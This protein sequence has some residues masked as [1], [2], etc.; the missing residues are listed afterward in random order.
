MYKRVCDHICGQLMNNSKI[1]KNLKTQMP[2]PQASK[3]NA[4]SLWKLP[5]VSSLI[6]FPCLLLR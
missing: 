5:K 2:T 6:A 4:I 1:K 3:Q